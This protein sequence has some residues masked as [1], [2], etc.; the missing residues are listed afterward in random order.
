MRYARILSWTLFVVFF[1][2]YLTAIKL[3]RGNYQLATGQRRLVQHI[4]PQY[5]TQQY[6]GLQPAIIYPAQDSAQTK[7]ARQLAEFLTF[8]QPISGSAS[9]ISSVGQQYGH[10]S[11]QVQQLQQPQQQSKQS[12]NFQTSNTQQTSE[13]NVLARRQQSIPATPAGKY[14]VFDCETYNS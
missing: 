11:Q 14:Q 2:I 10:Q 6:G 12:V 4:S 13:P 1:L 7:Q 3:V 8:Q 9:S 5:Y